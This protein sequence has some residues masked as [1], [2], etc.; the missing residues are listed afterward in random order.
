[1]S[2]ISRRG[3]GEKTEGKLRVAHLLLA[4][5][6]RGV[7]GAPICLLKESR[8]VGLIYVADR[9]A[10]SPLSTRAPPIAGGGQVLMTLGMP[11]TIP[12]TVHKRSPLPLSIV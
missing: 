3:G 2:L 11:C 12:S 9:W 8:H 6:R 1:M 5:S 7:M 4:S 10:W